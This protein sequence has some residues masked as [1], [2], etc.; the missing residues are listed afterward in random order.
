[1]ILATIRTVRKAAA[2]S[3]ADT[4]TEALDALTADPVDD[5]SLRR[6]RRLV[7]ARVRVF[8][9]S[10]AGVLGGA[11]LGVLV[12]VAIAAPL[13]AP[14]DP[15]VQNAPALQGPGGHY[16]LGTD[17]LGR[18]ILSRLIYGTRSAL[19][20]ATAV[21]VLSACIGVPL[22]V[23]SGYFT[24]WVDFVVMRVMDV[25]LALPGIL[26]ALV[27]AAILGQGLGIM[28]VAI[29]V[30]SIPAFARLAR[31]STL[32]EREAEYV[33]AA[34]SMGAGHTY[35]MFRSIL[36]NITGPIIVQFTVS[37]SLAIAA[38]ASLSFL[39]VALP[40]PAPT[41]G[42]MLQSAVDYLSQAPW[43]GIWP[44]LAL[45]IAIAAFDGLGRGL[46]SAF[47]GDSSSGTRRGEGAG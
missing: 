45:L 18:D 3:G 40:P 4:S 17:E 7:P 19:L 47:G 5:D 42:G 43:Y 15:L 9:R 14:H 20:I 35:I 31:S 12:I 36:P 2:K 29:A 8:L 21:G 23:I 6:R 11:T 28:I 30:A 34:R 10:P 1:M 13:I 39:G 27:V 22:G 25:L 24:G 26:L 38:A 33:L 41:W 32:A 16:L 37:A 44:G 46:Q